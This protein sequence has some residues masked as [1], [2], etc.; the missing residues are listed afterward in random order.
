M[1]EFEATPGYTDIYL[2]RNPLLPELKYEW[3]LEL[4]YCKADEEKEV[5]R[6]REEVW[7]NYTNIYMPTA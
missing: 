5:P 4:K 3:I 2:Q 6:K 1:S 7:R